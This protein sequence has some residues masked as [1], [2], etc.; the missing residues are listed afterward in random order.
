MPYYLLA[1]VWVMSLSAPSAADAAA[2]LDELLP[3]TIQ[4]M[5][6]SREPR[7]RTHPSGAV[8]TSHRYHAER[9]SLRVQITDVG[10]RAADTL[11]GLEQRVG[12]DGLNR[13]QWRDA[14]LFTRKVEMGRGAFIDAYLPLGRAVLSLRLKDSAGGEVTVAQLK[15][16]LEGLD[17]A[18]LAANVNKSEMPRVLY[19]PLARVEPRPPLDAA[20]LAS[21][22][23]EQVA[24]LRRGEIEEEV[25]G[26]GRRAVTAVTAPY[27]ERARITIVDR[28]GLPAGYFP[29]LREGVRTGLFAES[30][31]SGVPVFTR[32]APGELPVDIEV[33]GALAVA[34]E[35]FQVQVGIVGNEL[36]PQQAR[37]LLAGLDLQGLQALGQRQVDQITFAERFRACKPAD[38]IDAPAY[39][40]GYRYEILG[41]VDG[42]CEVR[43]RYTRNPN[44]ELVGPTMTCVWDNSR[45]FDEVVDNLEA[46]RGPLRER[47]QG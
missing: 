15:G 30:A 47:L 17:T 21:F 34:G 7:T 19:D 31:E 13:D 9:V 25:H 29:L 24:D 1:L 23:P 28:G 22:L 35:R 5:E 18:S 33:P 2:A 26:Y 38:F 20:S 41:P 40:A 4:E 46:C 39:N 3:V 42:G 11:R 10:E 8:Q 45:D 36:R 32:V 37:V 14:P 27:G 44:T 12:T 43:G 16:L 6:A